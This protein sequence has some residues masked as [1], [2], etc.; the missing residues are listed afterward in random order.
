MS[1]VDTAKTKR[2][3]VRQSEK[4]RGAHTMITQLRLIHIHLLPITYKYNTTVQDQ[5]IMA[6]PT[7]ISLAAV[8]NKNKM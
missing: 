5:V 8:T 3:F 7:L 2:D 1:N 6:C 4:P